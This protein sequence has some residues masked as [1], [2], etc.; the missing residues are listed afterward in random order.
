MCRRD[1]FSPLFILESGTNVCLITYLP[2]FGQ[3]ITITAS[4]F[5][6]RKERHGGVV[7]AQPPEQDPQQPCLWALAAVPVIGANNT[8]MPTSVVIICG[9]TTCSFVVGCGYYISHRNTVLPAVVPEETAKQFRL[10]NCDSVAE[11]SSVH[12]TI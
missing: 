8:N 7:Q 9:H 2:I 3:S 10:P 12:A 1:N 6:G 11:Y 4:K 5:G